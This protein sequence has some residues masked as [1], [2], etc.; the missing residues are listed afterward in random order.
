MDIIAYCDGTTSVFEIALITSIELS[1][2]VEEL[3]LLSQH[4]LIELKDE[5]ELNYIIISS[6]LKRTGLV[7]SET[8]QV[9]VLHYICVLKL[10]FLLYKD[11]IF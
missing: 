3:K 1:K 10:S 4:S 11:L 9:I 7:I 5:I 2:V 8:P 6:L